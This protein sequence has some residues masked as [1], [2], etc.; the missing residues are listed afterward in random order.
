MG[1]DADESA[2]GSR[3]RYWRWQ[4]EWQRRI[5][6]VPE[7]SDVMP[8]FV[9][10]QDGEQGQ[11][12]RQAAGESGGAGEADAEDFEQAFEIEDRQRVAEV[13][14][15]VRA[16]QCCGEKGRDEEQDVQPESRFGRVVGFVG[17]VFEA[18][19]GAFVPVGDDFRGAVCASQRG[20]IRIFW[21]HESSGPNAKACQRRRARGK[22]LQRLEFLTW[23]KA[24]RFAGRDGNLGAG[25]RVT[26]NAG[27]SGL[28]G[29]DAKTAQFNAVTLFECALHF[30]E[31]SFHG[32]FGLRFGD[33]CLV[34]N[35]VYDVEFDQGV[36]QF[37]IE[38]RNPDKLMIVLEL[39]LCQGLWG[40][41]RGN[42]WKNAVPGTK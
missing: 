34:D 27:F 13:E 18:R 25:S 5:D 22:L 35:F 32:H 38:R 9:G 2:K 40:K 1:P 37:R 41:G 31:D 8:H 10:H 42:R 6:A 19:D 4:K 15:H 39:C 24:H 26:A 21:K 3:A 28:D 33:S 29:E 12:K 23:F 16:D 14:H 7:A 36:P 11:R 17:R 30:P 20:F